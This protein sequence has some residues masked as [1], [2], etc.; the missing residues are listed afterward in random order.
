MNAGG[1][2]VPLSDGGKLVLKISEGD[3]LATKGECASGV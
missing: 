2:T 3:M 1:G